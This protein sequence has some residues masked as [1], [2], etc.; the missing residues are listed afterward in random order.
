MAGYTVEM[1][2]LDQ[3][4]KSLLKSPEIIKE[5]VGKFLQRGL[6]VYTRVILNNP[7]SMGMSGGGVPVARK[8]GGNLRDTHFK[9]VEPWKAVIRPTAPYASYVHGLDGKKFNKKGVQ[10]RPWLDYAVDKGKKDIEKLE[11]ELLENI[12]AT[13][14]K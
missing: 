4:K 2:G 5:E 1:I 10:L 14:A 11:E 9:S 6:A 7:W 3:L 13:L 8:N 12:V